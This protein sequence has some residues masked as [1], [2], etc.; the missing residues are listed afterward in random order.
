MEPRKKREENIG[1]SKNFKRKNLLNTL[2]VDKFAKYRFTINSK[3]NL[4]G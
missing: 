4:E 3:A 2:K 1:S